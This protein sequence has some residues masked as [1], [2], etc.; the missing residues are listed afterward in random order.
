MAGLLQQSR[1]NSY[2]SAWPLLVNTAFGV[3]AVRQDWLNVSRVP[4]RSVATRI[5]HIV[6]PAAVPMIFPGMRISIGTA[7]LVIVVAEMVVGQ[8]GIGFF[9]WNPFEISG[10]MKQ[11]VGIVRALAIEPRVLLLDEP[12]GAGNAGGD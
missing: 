11:R 6:F 12:F 7:W 10:G 2:P 5:R 1:W 4:G 8:S 9:I 3:S